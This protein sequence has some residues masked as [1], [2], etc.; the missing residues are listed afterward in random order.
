MDIDA[1]TSIFHVAELAGHGRS[2]VVNWS[3]VVARLV[4]LMDRVDHVFLYRVVIV[5][6]R[7][8]GKRI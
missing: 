2:F 3:L 7:M 4:R 5:N 6:V 1:S 8:G